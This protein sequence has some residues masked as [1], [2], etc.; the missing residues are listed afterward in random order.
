MNSQ[1]FSGKSNYKR[2]FLSYFE[3]DTGLSIT[4]DDILLL[5]DRFLKHNIQNQTGLLTSYLRK[6]ESGHISESEQMTKTI[7][8]ADGLANDNFML[9]CNTSMHQYQ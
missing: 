7:Q 3:R 6:L 1:T 2:E 4:D 9:G 5:H 8:E